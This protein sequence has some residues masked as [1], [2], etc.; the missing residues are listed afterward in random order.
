MALMA[1]NHLLKIQSVVTTCHM[2]VHFSWT[3]GNNAHK[4]SCLQIMEVSLL[5]L[6]A[7]VQ[8]AGPAPLR[9]TALFWGTSDSGTG[10]KC[11]KGLYVQEYCWPTSFWPRRKLSRILKFYRENGLPLPFCQHSILWRLCIPA[12]GYPLLAC[13]LAWYARNPAFTWPSAPHICFFLRS[14]WDGL[15]S[16]SS[17]TATGK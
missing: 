11:K 4:V 6:P 7:R 10:G 1:S 13:Q 16:L 5:M 8:N 9:N 17:R 15:T 2:A 12:L 14:I 3:R